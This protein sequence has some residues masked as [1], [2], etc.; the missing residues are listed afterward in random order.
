[1]QG[2]NSFPDRVTRGNYAKDWLPRLVA[3]S[4]AGLV[5]SIPMGLFM[6]GLNRALSAHAEPPKQITARVARRLGLRK[7]VHPGRTWEP[8][9]WAAHLGYGAASASLFP[10]VTRSLPIPGFL[11]GMLFA[12]GIWAA[13]YMG[14]L[15]A[16]HILP[17][18]NKQP[19]RRNT[20]MIL[21]HLLW[22]SLIGLLDPRIENAERRLV[23]R[24]LP[25]NTE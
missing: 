10:L 20:V 16:A 17:P 21:S 1:M 12:L 3:G 11:R 13:S 23:F 25:E 8:I 5:A 15:P 14:W 19:A 18:A 2:P 6:I 4:L 9:T 7:A 24:R 22:G